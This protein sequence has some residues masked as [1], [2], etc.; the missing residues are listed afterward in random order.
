MGCRDYH[1]AFDVPGI[2]ERPL[3]FR[4][5][6]PLPGVVD[7]LLDAPFDHE[8]AFGAHS[9]QISR[10]PLRSAHSARERDSA[11]GWCEA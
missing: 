2:A 3:D 10:P 1:V 9:H 6:D 7:M 11:C 5:N 8:D 4:G